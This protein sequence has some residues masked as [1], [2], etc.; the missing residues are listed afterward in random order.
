MKP[1]GK[2]SS[3][4]AGLLGAVI[5]WLGVSQAVV[6]YREYVPATDFFEASLQV[7]DFKAGDNP[8][9]VYDRSIKADFVG[10]FRVEVKRASD[11]HTVCAGAGTN[12]HYEPS[13]FLESKDTTFDWYVGAPCHLNLTKGVQYYL[14]SS[15]TISNENWPTKY[16]NSVS[17]IFSVD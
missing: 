2:T 16:Y 11:H 9:V 15:W 10:G 5:V 17:N 6:T 3:I 7:P 4:V 1:L 12:I 13:E 8:L 14:E